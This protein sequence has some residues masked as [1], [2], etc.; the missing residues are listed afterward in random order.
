ML[1]FAFMNQLHVLAR[2]RVQQKIFTPHPVT[3]KFDIV[4]TEFAKVHHATWSSKQMLR[5]IR[6]NVSVV[7]ARDSAWIDMSYSHYVHAMILQGCHLLP[8]NM[9]LKDDENN[10]DPNKTT[11]SKEHR[12]QIQSCPSLQVCY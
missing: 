3:H 8:P 9:K 1:T 2:L 12:P 4:H 5:Q 11:I 10:N 6:Q 7:S